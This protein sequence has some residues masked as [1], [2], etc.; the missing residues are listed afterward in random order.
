MLTIVPYHTTLDGKPSCV[1]Y[2]NLNGKCVFTACQA[3]RFGSTINYAEE[4]IASIA[5]QEGCNP[6]ELRY[7]DLQTRKF[8]G[9]DRLTRPNPGDFLFDEVVDWWEYA[10]WETTVC[11]RHVSDL[12]RDY[13]D[14]EPNQVILPSWVV[15]KILGF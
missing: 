10:G 9:A 14:G 11:P 8:S 13:I 6:R 1:A 7:F 15:K 4:V 12:F 2:A 3:S 5:R